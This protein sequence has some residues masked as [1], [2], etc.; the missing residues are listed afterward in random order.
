MYL[1]LCHQTSE[2]GGKEGRWE[3]GGPELEWFSQISNTLKV[4]VNIFHQ[5]AC[6]I[7]VKFRPGMN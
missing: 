2:G 6:Q 4:N 1:L 7:W 5:K 3:E